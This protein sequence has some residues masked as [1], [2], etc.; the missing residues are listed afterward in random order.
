MRLLPWCVRSHENTWP[1]STSA[2]LAANSSTSEARPTSYSESLRHSP[3]SSVMVREI[4][5][6]REAMISPARIR[7]L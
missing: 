1:S 4:S 6:S 2:W 3:D 5:S 7:I